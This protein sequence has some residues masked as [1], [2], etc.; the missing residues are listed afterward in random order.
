MSVGKEETVLFKALQN[1]AASTCGFH[2]TWHFC[3]TSLIALIGLRLRRRLLQ[4]SSNLTRVRKF[5]RL[6][7]QSRTTQ[8]TYTCTLHQPTYVL[9]AKSCHRKQGLH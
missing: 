7:Y 5:F 8:C 3:S 4:R 2:D 1:L 6:E 9:W